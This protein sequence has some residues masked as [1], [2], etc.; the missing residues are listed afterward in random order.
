ML[1]F[2]SRKS[3]AFLSHRVNLQD[4]RARVLGSFSEHLANAAR[5]RLENL[6]VEVRGG[7]SVLCSRKA[8]TG[9]RRAKTTVPGVG[10]EHLRRK[11][12]GN[13]HVEKRRLDFLNGLHHGKVAS[14]PQSSAPLY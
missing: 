9:W 2:P 10:K 6:G 13:D 4:F 5:Q 8:D 11:G 1:R 14:L 12:D 3:L 7:Q